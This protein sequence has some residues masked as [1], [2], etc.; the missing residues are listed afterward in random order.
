LENKLIHVMG[1]GLGANVAYVASGSAIGVA[2]TII[3][4]PSAADGVPDG[5][6]VEYFEP[7][8]ILGL[9]AE[10][11]RTTLEALMNRVGDPKQAMIAPASDLSMLDDQTTRAEIL[12][13]LTG[14]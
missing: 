12:A 8:D 7:N 1:V 5:A 6:A 4:S 9:A 10:S 11:E 13:W 3:I 14:Q 2:R